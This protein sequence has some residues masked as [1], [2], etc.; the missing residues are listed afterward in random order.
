AFAYTYSTIHYDSLSNGSTVVTPINSTIAAYNAF[1]KAGGGS[2]CYVAGT[3]AACTAAGA[4][5]NPYYN[6]P[7]QPMISATQD[8]IPYTFFPGGPQSFAVQYGS[9]YVASLAL[10]YKRD[11]FT[12]TPLLQ[13]A[14]GA[15]YG[16]PET[17]TG[18]NPATCGAPLAGFS[19][20]G[21]P[22]YP[23]GSPGG[24]AFDA[25]NC[26]GRIVIPDAYTG[27]FDGLGSFVQP[28]E[29]SLN[30]Q[31]T[32][33]V[34]PRVTLVGTFTNIVNACMGGTPEAWTVSG[35]CSYN[36]LNNGGAFPAIGNVYNPPA[37]LA[38]FPRL[39]QYP[40]GAYYGVVNVN[41]AGGN[42]NQTIQP[43]NF[44][45]EARLKL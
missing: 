25:T 16:E 4:V 39:L 44:Y 6:A 32:Y 22:R 28:A 7:L 41:T 13:F 29:L 11:K 31:T 37:T 8:F 21:D 23:Y 3:A 27:A 10:N 38:T 24:G 20:T 26:T 9:P 30:L 17:T 19:S 5:A 35:I 43:F 40:Y 14:G 36:I 42:N 12:I 15:R 2:P 1:T 34:S 45:L 18:I 33:T